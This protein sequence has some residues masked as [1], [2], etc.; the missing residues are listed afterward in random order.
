MNVQLNLVDNSNGLGNGGV[1]IFKAISAGGPYEAWKIINDSDFE[2]NNCP[3]VYPVGQG[4]AP[5][6]YIGVSS[7]AEPGMLMEA[8]QTQSNTAVNLLGLQSATIIMTG[9]GVGPNAE[10][11]QFKLADP[12]A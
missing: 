4:E 11:Y 6:L 7:S 2:A 5:T 3:F 9:G 10:P 8:V 1:V 12:Q